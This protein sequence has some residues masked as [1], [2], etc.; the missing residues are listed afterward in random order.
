PLRRAP[1][2]VALFLLAWAATASAECAWVLWFFN[3]GKTGAPIDPLKAFVTQEECAGE[4]TS[5]VTKALMTEWEKGDRVRE[6]PPRHRGP[7]WGRRGSESGAVADA[8]AALTPT[9]DSALR[10]RSARAGRDAVAGVHRAGLD[11][12]PRSP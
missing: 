7:A 5:P 4:A 8:G 2:I 3:N 10:V 11:A 1:V 12:L 6:M 9:D